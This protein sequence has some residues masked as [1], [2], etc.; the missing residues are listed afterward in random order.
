MVPVNE[1][2]P[3]G[4]NKQEVPSVLTMRQYNGYSRS[5]EKVGA[6]KVFHPPPHVRRK[7]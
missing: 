2:T 1:A 3:Y 5:A 4:F 7:G 6:G